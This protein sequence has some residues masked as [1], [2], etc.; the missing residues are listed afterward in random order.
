MSSEMKVCVI[1]AGG[2]GG[3]FGARLAQLEDV[4]VIF[5]LRE[6]STNL[7]PMREHGLT[8][9]S[10]KGGGEVLHARPRV[11]TSAAEVGPCDFVLVCVKTFHLLALANTLS[12]LVCD[13][14]QTAVVPLCAAA[15][16]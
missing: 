2:V 3:Y 13:V 6:S 5:L 12:P 1:G 11:A 16:R 15:P 7:A 10:S 8:V 14:R 4:E 9:H